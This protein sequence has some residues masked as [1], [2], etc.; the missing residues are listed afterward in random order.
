MIWACFAGLGSGHLVVSESTINSSKY[1]EVKHDPISPT[2]E[3]RP[4]LVH[5]TKKGIPNKFTTEQQNNCGAAVV[6]SPD[7]Y[8]SEMLWW[9]LK[10]AVQNQMLTNF[11]ELE[12]CCKA[13]WARIPPEPRET[14]NV[15]QKQLLSFSL[16]KGES[17]SC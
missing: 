10:R 3:E 14:N 15:V 8:L 6:Q 2:T 5:A 12:Q 17:A 7:L 4:K 1:S 13:P 9:D 16:L 11:S